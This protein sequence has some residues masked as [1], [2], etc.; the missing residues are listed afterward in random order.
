[1]IYRISEAERKISAHIIFS[2]SVNYM[3]VQSSL[4]LQVRD[5]K[6]S[7]TLAEINFKE[8]YQTYFT[9]T[10]LKITFFFY[11]F[12]CKI[13]SEAVIEIIFITLLLLSFRQGFL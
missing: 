10:V 11:T 5:V 12:P 4:V 8:V 13:Y 7:E 1:M 2:H 3:A 9:L 6:P